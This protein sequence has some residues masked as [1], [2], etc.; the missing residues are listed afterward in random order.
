VIAACCSGDGNL[1]LATH[2]A[3][4]LSSS[5]DVCDL[6]RGRPHTTSRRMHQKDSPGERPPASVSRL[7]AVTPTSGT[8]TACSRSI[9]SSTRQAS[10]WDAIVRSAYPPRERGDDVTLPDRL[11]GGPHGDHR[12]GDLHSRDE[13]GLG[14]D[15]VPS[16]ACH[17]VCEVDADDPILDEHVLGTGLGSP[18]SRG[19]K[20]SASPN[21]EMTIALIAECP[22]SV[23]ACSRLTVHKCILSE[24]SRR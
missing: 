4:D 8:A 24:K 13:R 1:L 16:P 23:L 5:E 12:A 6:H 10:R 15:V 22:T 3:D 18:T 20:T 9:S 7:Y 19:S 17:H 21:W 14:P 11:H 2:R